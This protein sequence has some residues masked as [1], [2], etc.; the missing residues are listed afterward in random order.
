MIL[1]ALCLTLGLLVTAN[2]EAPDR[3]IFGGLSNSGGG[4][5]GGIGD[6]SYN[7]G[8]IGGGGFGGAGV[9]GLNGGG[10]LPGVPAPGGGGCTYY[11][12][13]PTGKYICCPTNGP[14]P[15][16]CPP[17]RQ[18][19]PRINAPII[20]LN[21]FECIGVDKCCFDRCLG[22]RTCKSPKPYK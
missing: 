11:C 3:R 16:E 20:C 4:F 21:D 18:T 1:L 14:K 13:S 6:A 9:N 10:F 5:G 7:S 12:K 17:V 19:C 8:G 15:G 2:D 22:E